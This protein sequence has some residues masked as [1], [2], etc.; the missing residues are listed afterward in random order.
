MPLDPK[1]RNLLTAIAAAG[2]PPIQLM[3]AGKA[4]SLIESRFEQ[5]RLPLEKVRSVTDRTI[6]GPAGDLTLRIILLKETG[7]SLSSFFTMEGAG[8]YSARNIMIRYVHI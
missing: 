3:Q 2:D 5:I 1:A 7:L 4:R 6:P 8:F